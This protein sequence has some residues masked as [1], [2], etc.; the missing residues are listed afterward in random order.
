MSEGIGRLVKTTKEICQ[1]CGKGH[2]QIRCVEVVVL[3]KGE[4]VLEDR[5]FLLCPV[6]GSQEQYKDKKQDGKNK[7]RELKKVEE[8][9]E[10]KKYGHDNK[11]KPVKSSFDRGIKRSH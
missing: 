4:D 1:W 9:K 10:V 8:V 7:H 6:C 5:K 2:L 11:R 3:V